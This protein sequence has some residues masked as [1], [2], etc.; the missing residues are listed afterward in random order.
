MRPL[1]H[2]IASFLLAGL[3]FYCSRAPFPSLVALLAGVFIDLDHLIDFWSLKPKRPFSIR[4]FLASEQWDSQNR[5]IFI[6]L[7]AWEW[8]FLLFFFSWFYQWPLWLFSLTLSLALHLFLDALD[9]LFDPLK[10]SPRCQGHPL[11]YFFVFRCVKGFKKE[12]KNFK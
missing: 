7:H 3:I 11:T 12:M 1:Y 10:E 4:D 9:L 5:Y 2:I 8:I 6:F